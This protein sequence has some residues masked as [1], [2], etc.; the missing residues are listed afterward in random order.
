MFA[1]YR[2]RTLVLD[3]AT[4]PAG[5]SQAAVIHA[6]ML[7]TLELVG[8]VGETLRREVRAACGLGFR[9]QLYFYEPW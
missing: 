5:H 1:A 6:K 8:I 4:G 7:E 9:E 2:I 3:R